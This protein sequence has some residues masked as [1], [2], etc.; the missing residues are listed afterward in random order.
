MSAGNSDAAAPPDPL[1]MVE[2][3][4]VIGGGNG[5][6]QEKQCGGWE[7]LGL[8][9]EERGRTGKKG[10][11]PADGNIVFWIVS[12]FSRSSGSRS[13]QPTAR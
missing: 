11:D 8:R 1:V 9:R 10:P 6:E 4:V 13:H 3:V 12:V 5:K 7:G 2:P